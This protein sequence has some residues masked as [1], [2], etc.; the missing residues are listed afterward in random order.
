MPAKRTTTDRQPTAKVLLVDDH[1]VV[2]RGLAELINQAPDLEVWAEAETARD[3]MQAVD[4]LTPDVAI[5]DLSLKDASGLELIKDIK[6]QHPEL[7]VL[8]LSMHDESLYAERAVRAGARGYVMKE[9]PPERLMTAIHNVLAGKL[10]LSENI[11]ARIIQKLVGGTTETDGAPLNV[12]S[13]RELEVFELIGRGLAMREIAD[14]L[15]LSVKTVET[16][17]ENIKKKLNLHNSHQLHQ[18]AFLWIH[19]MP[20]SE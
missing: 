15:H 18:H 3:A 9:E 17:R 2:R 6:A 1:P 10:H 7:P 12:L 19:G 11:S 13:D 4:T 14:T 20:K 8:V 5:V 16:H